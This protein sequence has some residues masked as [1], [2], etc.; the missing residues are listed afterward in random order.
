MDECCK[1]DGEPYCKQ[2]PSNDEVGVDVVE[3]WDADY[4][5]D[6]PS[7]F[8]K[9]M[10]GAP[11]REEKPLDADGSDHTDQRVGNTCICRNRVKSEK[12]SSHKFS[13]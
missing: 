11:G 4:G 5:E 10:E 3:V 7:G 6:E 12:D 13:Q 8:P 9:P 1:K 2:S